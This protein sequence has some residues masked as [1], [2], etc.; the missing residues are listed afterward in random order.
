MIGT[1]ARHWTTAGL[2][3]LSWT[4]AGATGAAAQVTEPAIGA[5]AADRTAAEPTVAA[6]AAAEVDPQLSGGIVVTARLRSETLQDVP[7]AISAFSEE[8]LIANQIDDLLDLNAVVPNLSVAEL[9]GSGIAQIYLRG[10]GQDDSAAASEQPIGIYIDGV[11]YT[12]SPGA[13]MDLIDFERVEVLRGPQGT[14]YGRNSTGGAIKFETRRPSLTETRVV[15]DATVGSFSRLDFRGAFSTPLSPTFAVKLDVVSRSEY[16]YVRDALAGPGNS[17]PRRYNGTDR[18]TARLSGLWRPTERLTLFSTVDYTDDDAG[19]QSGVPAISS[20]PEDNLVD[21][22]IRQAR[23]LYGARRA[24]PTLFQPQSFEAYGGMLR[25]EYELDAVELT[26]IL[27]YRGFELSQGIDTDGGPNVRGLVSQ[28]GRVFDRGFDF[29]FVRDWSNDT[30]TAEVRAGSTGSGPLTWVAGVFLMREENDSVDIFGRFSEAAPFNFASRF[31]FNQVTKS[32]AVFGEATYAVTPRLNLT[33]GGRFTYDT[34]DVDRTHAGTLGLGPLGT[35]YALQTDEDWSQFTPRAIVD[36][37]FT[38]DV[39]AYASYSRGFQAGAYQSFPFSPAT[40][41][42]PFDP[43]T[44]NSYELGVRSQFL[45]RRLTINAT[46]FRADYTDL[47]STIQAQQGALV[48][49]TNDV[50]IQGIELEV[51]ARPIDGL[52]LY[53]SA[54]FVDDDYRRSVV[55]PSLVPG[56]TENRLKYVADVTARA[57]VDYEIPLGGVSVTLGG[58][59]THS[60]DFFMSTVNTPFSFQP[61]YTVYGTRAAVAFADDRLGLEV[62]V[63]NLTD[64]LYQYR[65]SAGGGGIIYFA[66]PRQFYATLRFRY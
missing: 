40:A 54:G 3:T 27:A 53:G 64:E 52:S 35:P 41:N 4:I 66:P 9:T 34:K 56:A 24:A 61:A 7:I 26:A 12:K 38:D 13:I 31:D 51:N 44:V 50:R 37:S 46:A 59:L 11:P 29:D 10:A 18:Q 28:N 45:D 33:L 5:D 47:P 21:G 20:R 2:A 65:A 63:R 32:A 43:T 62:G 39:S 15:G 30:L 36:Y 1:R 42:T 23:P 60:G 22:R 58:N 57:G 16:G 48:V 49:L 25:A 19:P 17:R 14:L 8:T 6:D 55:A